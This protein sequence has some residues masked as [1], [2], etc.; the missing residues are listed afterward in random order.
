[1]DSQVK[2]VR[3]Q[4]PAEAINLSVNETQS[5][6]AVIP[7]RWCVSKAL[8][9]RL[10]RARIENPYLLL[11][12]VHFDDL[13]YGREVC[14]RFIPLDRMM[15]YIQFKSP[16][17]HKILAAVVWDEGNDTRSLEKF[18]LEKTSTHSYE[19]NVLGY[20]EGCFR[21]YF[22][23]D[24]EFSG[25]IHCFTQSPL[26]IEV[27]KEFFAKEPPKWL[28]RW[29][30]LWFTSDPQDQC[31]F[32]RRCIIAFTI[33]PVAVLIW[34]VIMFLLGAGIGLFLLSCGAKRL[35]FS[36]LFHPFKKLLNDLW[37]ESKGSV[38]FNKKYL[39][40]APFAPV[41]PLL[42]MIILEGINRSY[43]L[44]ESISSLLTVD[45]ALILSS[46]LI[47]AS[48][49]LIGFILKEMSSLT[50]EKERREAIEI[51]ALR[52]KALKDLEEQTQ[53]EKMFQARFGPIVCTDSSLKPDIR[54]LP[55]QKRTIYLRYMG[56]KAK[57][58]KP[59]AKY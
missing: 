7:V 56:L 6:D 31:Q 32:R 15:E 39:F 14:R 57:I 10:K 29:A 22:Y 24:N 34:L 11:V 13:S 1:M 43:G 44:K 58:C 3:E 40:I 37:A 9:E 12:A 30:N 4:K 23:Y 41:F 18:F 17:K 26:E 59:F 46:S 52:R 5:A 51:E 35:D 42:I 48:C 8:Y 16:G 50:K 33:Q 19:H 36:T 53:K 55:K 47:I 28:K 20:N 21:E 49:Q 54:T 25:K 45:F 27:A 2:T 38:F